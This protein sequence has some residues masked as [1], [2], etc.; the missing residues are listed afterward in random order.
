MLS[1]LI[2]LITI[3]SLNVYVFPSSKGGPF[4][5]APFWLPYL[6]VVLRLRGKSPRS[7]LALAIAMSCAMIVPASWLIAYARSWDASWQI[8][9]GLAVIVLSQV[10]LTLSALRLWR[11]GPPQNAWRT[12]IANAAYAGI[13]LLIL[14]S[15]L[16]HAPNRIAE[17]EAS[18]RWMLQ[19]IQKA[20]SSYAGQFG[21]YPAHLT[22]LDA[23]PG[24]GKGTCSAA[25]LLSLPLS[26]SEPDTFESRGWG[27]GYVFEY[28][29]GTAKSTP[30]CV[31]ANSYQL[32]ARPL[33]FG[34]TGRH[35]FLLEETGRV[36]S[37]AE[38]RAA[39]VTDPP[40]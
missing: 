23:P 36:R 21:G 26:P 10:A 16:W 17:D 9:A 13:A 15:F 20:A 28:A 11:H 14:T 22:A 27:G 8:Q 33:I 38:N 30:A 29:A 39:E 24:D 35:S 6:F 37:T 12:I 18:T 7:G 40:I 4:L 3:F 1:A 5:S 25:G 31:R 19:T 32:R 2:S 34:K